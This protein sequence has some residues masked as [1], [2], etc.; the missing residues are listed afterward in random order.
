MTKTIKLDHIT[1]IEG[2]ARLHIRI[3]GGKVKECSL[4]IFEGSRFFEGILKGKLWNDLPNITSRICGVC[5]PVHTLTSVKAIE[6]AFGVRVSAQ[7]NLLRELINIGGILQSHA[8][9]LYFLTLP[10]YTGNCSALDML[11][12]YKTE[13]ERALRIKR[14]GNAMVQLLGGRDIHPIAIVPGGISRIPEQKAVDTLLG[15]LKAIE[16]DAK[17]TVELFDSL[18]YPKFEH[19]KPLVAL[20]NGPYFDSSDIVTC[21]D[22]KCFLTKDYEQHFKEFFEE[23]STAEFVTKDGKSYM[24]G[25]LA[26]LYNNKD[27]TGKWSQKYVT[28]ALNSKY[29]PYMNNL[30]QAIEIYEG[31]ERAINILENIKLKPEQPKP[32]VPKASIGVG[33]S[34]APRGILFH[35]YVFDKKGYCTS[36]NITTPT[37]Q[38]LLNLQEAIKQYLPQILDKDEQTIKLEIE[39]LIR[40]YDPCISC[41]THFL[42]LNVE[43][44]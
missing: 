7:T 31:V 36:A 6:Q 24:V 19:Y 20:G 1:K 43:R 16:K 29:S 38:N 17:L 28:K 15:E 30:A 18:K 42:E 26:R 8:L 27:Q 32:I 37:S 9:H 4:K 44:V 41:S 34:E 2:H 5:S 25:A 21:K 40:A 10:D 3:D 33:A 23:D 11:P 12:K 22:D 39:K 13:I 35:K 14:A